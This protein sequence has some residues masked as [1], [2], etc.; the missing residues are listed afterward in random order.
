MINSPH[1]IP[2]LQLHNVLW[3]EIT[4]YGFD[5]GKSVALLA[6]KI[7]ELENLSGFDINVVYLAGLL[8]DIGR[9][10]PVGTDD[11]GHYLKG[12]KLAEDVLKQET[13]FQY[14]H[15]LIKEVCWLI[16]NHGEK[17]TNDRR[18]Q[19]LQDADRMDIVR[20]YPNT[21]DGLRIIK[22]GYE[23]DN[24]YTVFAKDKNNFKIWMRH[25]GWNI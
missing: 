17:N 19:V 3:P 15:D 2:V 21:H 22:K 24:M 1:K 18:L 6:S 8:H 7:S 13:E 9:E 23:A 14:Q 25:R 10:K 12:A 20:F 4:Y 11:P 5:H 16:L